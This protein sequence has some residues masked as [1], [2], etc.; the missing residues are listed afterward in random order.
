MDGDLSEDERRHRLAEGAA[1]RSPSPW[2]GPGGIVP[3]LRSRREFVV[4]GGQP[5]TGFS[6]GW[7]DALG[8]SLSFSLPNIASTGQ[9]LVK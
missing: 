8:R 7:G 5:G 3:S 9:P 6:D 2:V 4:E 1:V